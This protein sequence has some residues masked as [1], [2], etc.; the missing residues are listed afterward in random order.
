MPR[1][2]EGTLSQETTTWITFYIIIT[3]VS[4]LNHLLQCY[5]RVFLTGILFIYYKFWFLNLQQCSM[6]S[7]IF[8]QCVWGGAEN[9]DRRL[10]MHE[11]LQPLFIKGKVY[12]NVRQRYQTKRPFFYKIAHL[13]FLLMW[14]LQFSPNLPAKLKVK[15]F[16][17]FV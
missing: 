12:S 1:V 13:Y 4:L 9:I 7:N 3:T 6:L 10:A 8:Y 16:Y 17:Y 15:G 2:W 11:K 14:M 5:I